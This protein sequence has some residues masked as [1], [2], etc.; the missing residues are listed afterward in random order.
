MKYD[1]NSK[2]EYYEV[3]NQVLD[4]DIGIGLADMG[5]IY[6]VKVK[7][8]IAVVTMTF[9]SMACPYGA[10]MV[11]QVND[12]MNRQPGIEDTQVEVV[13]TPAWTPKRMKRELRE[14]IFG[15]FEG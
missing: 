11:R 8:K 6:D 9:T 2:N 10:D 15:D 14:M 7:D 1:F 4:P 13:F 5:L 3:L 12:V